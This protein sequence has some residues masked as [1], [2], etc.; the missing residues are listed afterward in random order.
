MKEE[1]KT[2]TTAQRGGEIGGH[3]GAKVDGGVPG[4]EGQGA[5]VSLVV[6]KVTVLLVLD[7]ELEGGGDGGHG[8]DLLAADVAQDLVEE[9]LGL[10]GLGDAGGGA[11]GLGAAQGGPD[12]AHA[13]VLVGAGV[14]LVQVGGHHR[15]HP[16][17]GLHRAGGARAH[18]RL[19][20]RAV[21]KVPRV[22][23]LLLRV[24]PEEVPQAGA[25][26]GQARRVRKKKQA[27]K[28]QRTQ[29]EG[30]GAREGGEKRGKEKERGREEE[31][32]R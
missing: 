20:G 10:G 16:R 31:K 9:L 8:E 21:R 6:D 28:R 27:S 23:A 17:L 30:W 5:A 24:R 22:T 25:A 19:A 4:A 15:Q 13:G 14:Q 2:T 1:K 32:E 26:K 12:L 7:G 29:G 3:L 18:R 11:L